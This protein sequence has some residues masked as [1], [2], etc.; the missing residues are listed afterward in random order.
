MRTWASA[1]VSSISRSRLMK[2]DPVAAQLEVI[3]VAR[4]R[5]WRPGLL[6]RIEADLGRGSCRSVE[7]SFWSLSR[8]PLRNP[9]RVDAWVDPGRGVANQ[10][11]Q[12]ACLARVNGRLARRPC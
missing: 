3:L 7:S 1:R 12:L 6:L 5:A 11:R 8:S 2:R 10:K 9:P 4:M